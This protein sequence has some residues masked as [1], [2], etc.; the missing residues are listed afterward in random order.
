ML[1]ELFSV[2]PLTLHTYGLM[3]A[4]GF[5]L[6]IWLIAR[7]GGKEGISQDIVYDTAF[8]TIIAAIIGARSVFALT[9]YQFFL[10]HPLEFFKIWRGGMVFYGGFLGAV[11]AVYICSKVYKFDLFLLGDII[12]PG[13]ALG[14]A[15]GRLGCFAAGCC[16]GIETSVPWAVIFTKINSMAPTGIPL[17]PTQVYDS[18]NEFSIFIIL[19]VMQRYKTFKGQIW[20]AWVGMYAIGRFIVE[21][22]R[23]DPRGVYFDGLLSTSQII[24]IMA[25]LIAIGGYIMNKKRFGSIV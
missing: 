14:H 16:Y 12:A 23:G 21:N 13:A 11:V 1:P 15:V 19:I 20:W 4:S 3:V 18:I 6:G 7:L 2:G 24:G 17:H 5:I 9:E 10:N 8:W 22:Y 25:L